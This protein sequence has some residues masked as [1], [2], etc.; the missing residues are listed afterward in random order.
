MQNV[1]QL[2][3]RIRI[4]YLNFYFG[5]FRWNGIL[6]D[7]VC[8]GNTDFYGLNPKLVKHSLLLQNPC[9]KFPE[10]KIKA[11]ENCERI[12]EAFKILTF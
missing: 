2:L 11:I 1:R 7:S 5:H 3:V 8:G 10:K 4:A 9:H 12:P 6:H